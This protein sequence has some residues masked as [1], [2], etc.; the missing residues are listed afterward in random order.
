MSELLS[1]GGGVI[2]GALFVLFGMTLFLRLRR[3][4]GARK[5]RSKKPPRVFDLSCSACHREMVIH[6]EEL[7]TMSPAEQALVVSA[8]PG[9]VGRPLSEFRCPYCEAAHCFAMDVQPPEWLGANFNVPQ[10]RADHCFE[11]GGLLRTP[12][13]VT[14]A[15]DAKLAEVPVLHPDYGLVC[16]YCRA[17]A[18]VACCERITLKR[19][20]DGSLACPR[21]FR[22]PMDRFYHPK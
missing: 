14:G 5:K 19:T 18:C 3:S 2:I 7:A 8:R 16:R 20:P 6:P 15:Y 4:G 1:D 9:M 17:V 12:E 11:C 21:C 22:Y 13:W 10:A